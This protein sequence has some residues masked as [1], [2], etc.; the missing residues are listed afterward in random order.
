MIISIKHWVLEI[1]ILLREHLD[2]I[3]E[4]G[5]LLPV[6]CCYLSAKIRLFPWIGLKKS[7]ITTI[8]I[9]TIDYIGLFASLFLSLTVKI[10]ISK[11]NLKASNVWTHQWPS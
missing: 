8:S 6:V 1:E 10:L 5:K 2:S 4:M 7:K 3:R 11:D 9:V